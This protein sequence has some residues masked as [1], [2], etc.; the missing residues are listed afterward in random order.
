MSLTLNPFTGEFDFTGSGQAAAGD[1]NF[2]YKLVDSDLTIPAGQQMI[3]YDEVVIDNATLTVDGCLVVLS[4]QLTTEDAPANVI[5]ANRAC[6]ASVYIGAVVYAQPNGVA[7]NAIATSLSTSNILGIV[8]SKPNTTLC[9][10]RLLG[11]TSAIFSSLDVTKEY[12]LSDSVAG[13]LQTTV[14]TTTG[15]VWLKIGQPLSTTEFVVLKGQRT[16]RL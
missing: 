12:Y 8:E 15:H 5:L 9:N 11:A 14:P 16:V 2:S 1:P 7:A 6:E 3:V 4:D 13:A 10:I